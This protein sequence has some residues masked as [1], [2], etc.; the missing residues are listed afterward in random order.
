MSKESKK[1][2]WAGAGAAFLLALL[3]A[4]AVIVPRVVDS[5]WLKETVR[6]EVAKRIN[7]DFDFLKAE[8]SI[9][10]APYVALQQV[11]LNIPGA[12]QVN[13][14]TIKVYPK[15]F[16]L[17]LGNI[18][19]DKIVIDKPDFSLPLPEKSGKKSEQ[20]A[21]F[22]L[23]EN[24]ETVSAKLS[25]ILSAIPGLD[26][27]VHKGTLR[28]FAAEQQVFLFENINGSFDVSSKTITL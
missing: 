16:P 25:P 5:A 28:F 23:S 22:S 7:G 6:T 13:L 1:I 24:L 20:E 10:P 26:V 4:L 12:A 8:I 14:D 3:L 27:G 9:L 17:L 18:E 11:S 21:P 15:L 2:Y 19:L